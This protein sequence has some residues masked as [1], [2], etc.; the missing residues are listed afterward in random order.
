MK[1][2]IISLTAAGLL[3]AGLSLQAQPRTDLNKLSGD[4]KKLL[5]DL[6]VSCL[7]YQGINAEKI[8]EKGADAVKQF[9]EANQPA[10]KMA[11]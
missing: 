4:D 8:K 10:K 11:E 6:G 2:I 7:E 3:L 5:L 1:I 9:L